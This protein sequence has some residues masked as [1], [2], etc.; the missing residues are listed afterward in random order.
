RFPSLL[1]EGPATSAEH[2]EERD[3]ER[4]HE[5]QPEQVADGHAAADGED[6][7]DQNDDPEQWHWVS[8]VDEFVV[9]RE[10]GDD[11]GL[12]AGPPKEP[13][14]P[15]ARASRERADDGTRTHDLLHGK[16]TL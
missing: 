14:S 6:D 11:P 3:D 15:R 1:L 5:Q 12:V 7:E 4:D 16:Q 10:N 13:G 2:P 9:A 8:L